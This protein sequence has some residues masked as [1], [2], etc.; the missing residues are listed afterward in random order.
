MLLEASLSLFSCLI[1]HYCFFTSFI[2]VIFLRLFTMCDIYPESAMN[3]YFIPWLIFLFSHESASYSKIACHGL[4]L[5]PR[6]YFPFLYP[7]HLF[8]SSRSIF[9]CGHYLESMYIPPIWNGTVGGLFN[10]TLVKSLI[11]NSSTQ[12]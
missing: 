5:E 1:F 9:L 2:F 10:C 4:C 11:L 12:L 3:I 6:F 7:C 8:L